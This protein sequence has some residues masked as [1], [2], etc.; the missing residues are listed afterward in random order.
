MVLVNCHHENSYRYFIS[1][2]FDQGTKLN[3]RDIAQEGDATMSH[4]AS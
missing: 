4:I 3:S 1:S 2:K